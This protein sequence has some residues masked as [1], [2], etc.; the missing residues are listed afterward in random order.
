[1]QINRLVFVDNDAS[2][3][4]Y[5]VFKAPQDGQ[6]PVPEN[7]QHIVMTRTKVNYSGTFINLY[8]SN[9]WSGVEIIRELTPNKYAIAY[10]S[11]N[12]FTTNPSV[13]K[14]CQTEI[15]NK[16]EIA[17]KRQ[18]VR[19]SDLDTAKC[20]PDTI[21]NLAFGNKLD[22]HGK[23]QNF[24]P[25]SFGAHL[26]LDVDKSFELDKLFLNGEM[27]PNKAGYKEEALV[28]YQ[29]H[30]HIFQKVKDQSWFPY[31]TVSYS[32]ENGPKITSFILRNYFSSPEISQYLPYSMRILCQSSRSPHPTSETNNLGIGLGSLNPY[33]QAVDF[34]R[35]KAIPAYGYISGKKIR[36]IEIFRMKKERRELDKERQKEMDFRRN[37]CGD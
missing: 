29:G 35:L 21:A 25:L 26:I 16:V 15:S 17:K 30:L 28:W 5:E 23:Y 33:F 36:E 20:A 6:F 19:W 24:A 27:Y 12:S 4:I 3:P 18:A 11:H 31:T 13:A 10:D 1:M 7:N 37:Y 9:V 22:I 2:N 14:E 32:Q 34:G 8:C